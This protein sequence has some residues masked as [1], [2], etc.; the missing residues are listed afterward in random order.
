MTRITAL[1]VLVGLSTASLVGAAPKPAFLALTPADGETYA[2]G[3]VE[4]VPEQVAA[5]LAARGWERGWHAG[6]KDLTLEYLKQFNAVVL[7]DL[8]GSG[9]EGPPATTLEVLGLLRQYVEAGGGLF[10]AQAPYW[11]KKTPTANALLAPMG[12]TVYNELVRD[13][14]NTIKI[15]SGLS[16]G[17]T[18]ALSRSPLTQG[19]RGLFY[20]QDFFEPA[21]PNTNPLEV[22]DEWEVVVRGLPTAASFKVAVGS[23]ETI[24]PGVFDTAPTLVAA[25]PWGKGRVVLWPTTLSYTL[26]DGYSPLLDNGIV[27][28][29]EVEGRRSDGARLVYNLLEWLM[30]PSRELAG[31]GGYVYKPT[32]PRTLENEP[33]FIGYDWTQQRPVQPMYDRAYLGLV[34]A[35]SNHS[36]G[37]ASPEEIIAAAKA[38]GYEYVVFTED[39]GVLKKAGWDQVVE[40]CKAGSD[41]TFQAFPGMYYKTRWGQEFIVFGLVGDVSYP[42]GDW[43]T[44][45]DGETRL[46]ENNAFVRGLSVVPA[47]AM[48]HPHRNPNPL[49]V[50]SQFYGFATHTYE[51]GRLV[52]EAFTEY[53][54]L[55]REGLL[56]FPLAVHFVK[57][58]A[59]VAAARAAEMQT[60]IR[61]RSLDTVPRSVE[62]FTSAP[63]NQPMW[64]KPGFVSSGPEMQWLWAENWGTSDQAARGAERHR[65]QILLTSPAGLR[66]VRIYDNARLWQRFRLR[67]ENTFLRQIDNYHDRQHSYV[68]EALDVQGGRA[69][70][71]SRDTSVQEVYHGMCGDNWNDMPGGK[72][73]HITAGPEAGAKVHLRGTEMVAPLVPTAQVWNYP[74]LPNYPGGGYNYATLKRSG[75]VT[76]FGWIVDYALD[77]RYTDP[78]W[79]G[80]CYDKYALVPN[81]WFR[82]HVRNYLVMGSTPRPN[83][84]MLEG[85]VTFIA[86]TVGKAT[87]A[88]TNSYIYGLLDQLVVPPG[89]AGEEM[90]VGST[91]PPPDLT[92]ELRPNEYV[93]T[94][95]A[96]AALVNLGDEAKTYHVIGP[97]KVAWVGTGEGG[98]AIKEGTREKWRLVALTGGKD[99]G[100]V[101]RVRRDMGLLGKTAYT[102]KPRVGSV[103]STRLFLRLKLEEGG[104]RGTI[105]RADLPLPLPVLVEGLNPNWTATIWYKGANTLLIPEWRLD[106]WR[107]EITPRAGQDQMQPVAAFQAGGPFGYAPETQPSRSWVS[108]GVGFLTVD[109]QEKDRDVFI[110][111]QVVCDQPE[112]R[113]TYLRDGSRAR[114]VVHNP[115]SRLV[116]TTLRPGKGYDRD[117]A[118]TRTMRVPAGST[119]EVEVG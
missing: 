105:S 18:D 1:L 60:Y 62:G 20:W 6:W 55:Q 58:A 88:F 95:P 116:S 45:V 80:G 79:P 85:D 17:W 25:R 10:L 99:E 59:E 50:N 83:F 96:L 115:T 22:S 110:G 117:G 66:E 47:I 53:L 108:D 63:Y 69:I 93:A 73:T 92:G 109:L 35:M 77:Y 94:F 111:H 51:A 4:Y 30:Q 23:S 100:M 87:P 38:A 104:F 91:T 118:W 12:A 9:P 41:A 39:L 11:A 89:V 36:R 32:P 86:D 48:V 98:E 82:G 16:F 68:V 43:T 97:A 27:M 103:V 49:R 42:P 21:S 90:V 71:W 113:L 81:P 13:D 101:E 5:A 2:R 33:G 106:P 8:P 54:E 78:G 34:G 24:G 114:V 70:S 29:G 76:R 107:L 37:E 65:L 28:E 74:F 84:T 56:L 75:L 57:S 67:G 52:D 46:L 61:A 14:A 44:E 19:V 64:V 31:W 26:L 112:L 102:V 3:E 15:K 7:Y 40:A 72:Y 119:V